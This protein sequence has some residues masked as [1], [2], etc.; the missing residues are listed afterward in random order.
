MEARW[1]DAAMVQRRRRLGLSQEA[2]AHAAGISVR[3]CADAERG[4]RSLSIGVGKWIAA[5]LDLRLQELLD[6]RTGWH[7]KK[8]TDRPA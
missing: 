4:S 1:L 5:A 3:Y 6:E 7:S 8:L 2:V